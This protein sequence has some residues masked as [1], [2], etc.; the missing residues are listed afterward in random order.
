MSRTRV[1]VVEDSITTR[2]RLV[3]A[4]A[5][6]PSIEVVGEAADG[7]RAVELCRALRPDV[8]SMDIVLPIMSGV[9]ATQEIM[10]W[11]PTPIVVVSASAN[12][13][14]AFDAYDALAAG[15]IEVLEKP[16]LD[17]T[18]EAWDRSLRSTLKLV[19]RIRPITHLRARWNARGDAIARPSRD[20]AER[21]PEPRAA[22]RRLK[23]IAI[24]ASTGGP[25]AIVRV[26][27]ELPGDCAPPILL[28]LHIHSGFGAGFV[29]WLRGQVPQPVRMAT[30]GE[31]LD[32]AGGVVVAPPGRHLRVRGGRL[33][34]FDDAEIHSC[35]PSID[36]LFE[37]LAEECGAATAAC[38]LTGM[39]VDGAA[40]LLALRNAGAPTLAQDEA[41][42]I[43]YGMPREAA[44]IGA[45][46]RILPLSEIGPALA[47][48]A[49]RGQGG[50]DR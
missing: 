25:S 10:A 48:L 26:L 30:D 19:A 34:L 28:V 38:L 20:A 42:S 49:P 41:S 9:D 37:S 50:I 46:Q 31:P 14:E 24:G 12:R 29:E 7:R 39:G 47:A 18:D 1:L 35:R 21:P 22:P 33:R 8:I 13:G 11:N 44:R 27:G 17:E 23:A 3:E 6:D 2:R 45:A 40:G 4:L 15:A 43:V 16:R 36:A 5:A 32:A